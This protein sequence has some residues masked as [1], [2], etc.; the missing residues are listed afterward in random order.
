[1]MTEVDTATAPKPD[2]R[3]TMYREALIKTLMEQRNEAWNAAA[4]ARAQIQVHFAVEGDLRRVITELEQRIALLTRKSHHARPEE[5][6][7]E[8]VSVKPD[9]PYLTARETVHPAD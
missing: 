7:E 8:V 5:V 2:P 1:M 9:A 3:L 6:P 4:E